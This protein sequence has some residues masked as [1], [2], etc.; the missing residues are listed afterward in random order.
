MAYNEPSQG[1]GGSASPLNEPFWIDDFEFN[2]IGAGVIPFGELGWDCSG[3]GSFGQSN[4][5]IYHPGCAFFAAQSTIQNAI[6]KGAFA[7]INIANGTTI[8]QNSVNIPTLSV[9]AADAFKCYFG[10][11]LVAVDFPDASGSGIWFSY[12]DADSSGNWQCN[13]CDFG[14]VTT[15]D[16]SVAVVAGTWYDLSFKCTGTSS[17]EFFING[18][19]VG[20]IST[21]L[22]A[23]FNTAPYIGCQW[24]NDNGGGFKFD[25]YFLKQILSTPRFTVLT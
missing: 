9:A 13:T 25:C 19:S 6:M 2:L 23:S 3:G 4:S 1:G 8:N 17:V 10:I 15:L 14:G 16:S 12:T 18:V 21:A 20:T 24:L 7:S 11:A 5:D 22:P